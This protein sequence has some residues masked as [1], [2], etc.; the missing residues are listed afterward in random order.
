MRGKIQDE[1]KAGGGGVLMRVRLA[2]GSGVGGWGARRALGEFILLDRVQE[3]MR[4]TYMQGYGKTKVGSDQEAS[5]IPGE[6]WACLPIP[7]I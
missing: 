3:G 1:T 2:S 4:S 7:R 5:D 6:R